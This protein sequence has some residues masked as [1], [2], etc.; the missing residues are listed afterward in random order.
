M[1]R[2]FV[3]DIRGKTR[4]QI[5]S[6]SKEVWRYISA[7]LFWL[8]EE[9]TNDAKNNYYPEIETHFYQIKAT[10][11]KV[12][13]ITKDLSKVGKTLFVGEDRVVCVDK[14]WLI[15]E[16]KLLGKDKYRIKIYYS[17]SKSSTIRN[18]IK[19][20][21]GIPSSKI[22]NNERLMYVSRIGIHFALFN[23][24]KNKKNINVIHASSVGVNNKA[25]V[26]LG[27]DGIGKSTLAIYLAKNNNYEIISDNFLLHDE[28]YIYPLPET[29][30]LNEDSIGI[31]DLN[32]IGNKVYG[33]RQVSLANHLSRSKYCC[34]AL[35][36]N[37][38]SD[39]VSLSS[40]SNMEVKNLISSMDCFLPEFIDYNRFRAVVGLVDENIKPYKV[41]VLAQFLNNIKYK[42]VLTKN[43]ISSI[44]EVAKRVNQWF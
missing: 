15:W 35:Y 28:K 32:S 18:I 21:I 2:N 39:N 31:L 11:Y 4:I 5:H 44:G 29:S 3:V 38:I 23:Y 26:L 14:P 40:I 12:D 30:R 8:K 34:R 24:L 43:D 1:K 41:D 37:T 22:T 6:K 25:H 16:F 19:K 13:S 10:I 20:Y 17:K 33:R 36:F 42:Y 27:F 7:N 9:E